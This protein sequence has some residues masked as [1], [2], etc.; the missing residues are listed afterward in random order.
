MEAR[1]SRLQTVEHLRTAPFARVLQLDKLQGAYEHHLNA[2]R[3]PP[4]ATHLL[5]GGM[6]YR[7]PFPT[8]MRQAAEMVTADEARYLAEAE[9]YVMSPQMS[10]V[11]VAAAQTLTLEDLDLLSEEDLPSMTGVLVLPHPLIVAA[12]NGDLGDLRAVTWRTPFSIQSASERMDRM[13][14][15]PAVRISTYNDT[16]GPVR[17][18]SF[19]MVAKQARAMGTP[20]PPLLQDGIRGYPLQYQAST[21][22]RETVR[23]RGEQARQLG[24]AAREARTTLGMNEDRVIGE[25]I[26]D[27]QIDDPEDTFALRFLYAF[28][29]LCEQ[30][31]AS[32]SDAEAGPV[33][34]QQAERARVAADVRIVQLRRVDNSAEGETVGGRWQ[35]RW[36]VR[37]HKVRQWY[38]SLGR[39]KVIYRGPYVKGPEDKPLLGGETVRGLIR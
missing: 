3:H 26:P 19:Q 38:P 4:T 33:T 11:V 35:H 17:P 30:R 32:T 39:H 1:R 5:L 37:M 27:S 25:Y 13:E 14:D 20:L 23:Q 15:Y 12:P 29:R 24:E 36:V 9:L 31:I 22:Q 16:N 34:R 2:V 10:D 21:V 8:D 7:P 6:G 18:D 28:W